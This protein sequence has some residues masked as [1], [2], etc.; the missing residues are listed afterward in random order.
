MKKLILVFILV[1]GLALPLSAKAAT[2]SLNLKEALQEEQIELSDAFETY[3]ETDDQAIIYLFRGNGC[4]YCRAFLT[5]LNN[6]VGEYG[7]YFK[8]ISYEVWYDQ[9]NNALLESVSKYLENPA[10]GVPYIVIGDKVFAGYAESYDN[11]IK[12]TIKALYDTNVSNRYDVMK[13]ME[14][15]PNKTDRSTIKEITKVVVISTIIAVVIIVCANILFVNYKFNELKNNKPV[16]IEEIVPRKKE[17][18]KQEE[19]PVKKQAKKTKKK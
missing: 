14:E 3:K 10:Q 12:S 9:E 18:K 2:K 19:K 6:I 15:N 5:F 1:L 7:K 4:G 13:E 11:D 8:V 17:E 16:T